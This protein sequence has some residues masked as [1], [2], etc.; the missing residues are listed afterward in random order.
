MVSDPKQ[1]SRLCKMHLQRLNSSMS[2]PCNDTGWWLIIFDIPIKGQHNCGD[3]ALVM[4]INQVGKNRM[5]RLLNSD[6]PDSP[7]SWLITGRCSLRTRIG[8]LIMIIKRAFFRSIW[9][10]S[11]ELA[12]TENNSREI[13]MTE[14]LPP[15]QIRR[16]FFLIS[17][18]K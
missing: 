12:G 2:R 15:K 9:F 16:L 8:N 1:R 17:V 4:S 3:S 18:R 14:D 13:E 7:A 5:K 6:R 11:L 10:S